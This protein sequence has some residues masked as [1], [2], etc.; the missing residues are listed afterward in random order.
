MQANF[1]IDE[2]TDKVTPEE[3]LPKSYAPQSAAVNR[4]KKIKGRIS[5][6]TSSRRTSTSQEK[7]E[8]EPTVEI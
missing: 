7:I 1:E 8:H 3:N 2:F 6:I 5:K 4:I